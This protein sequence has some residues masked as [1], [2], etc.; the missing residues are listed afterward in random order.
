MGIVLF[1]PPHT[2]PDMFNNFVAHIAAALN[3]E[4]AK[5]GAPTSLGG[6]FDTFRYQYPDGAVSA[7]MRNERTM[8]W[9]H[10]VRG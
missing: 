8:Q 6:I 4:S 5:R 9:E 10:K 2:E 1:I 7:V 3:A